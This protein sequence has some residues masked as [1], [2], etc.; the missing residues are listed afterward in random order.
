[1]LHEWATNSVKYGA[2]AEGSEG[3]LDVTWRRDGDGVVLDWVERGGVGGAASDDDRAGDV[4]GF[5]TLLVDTS[6][7]QLGATVTRAADEG[8]FTLALRLPGSVL[9][10]G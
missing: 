6:A 7:R 9:A 5:G 10:H 3:R 8:R 2:L 1:M 4:R